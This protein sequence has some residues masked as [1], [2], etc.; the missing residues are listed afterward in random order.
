MPALYRGECAACGHHTRETSD[1]YQA[2]VVDPPVNSAHAH[3]DD[4][5]IVVLPQPASS[6]VLDELGLT[7][8]SATFAGR[9][10]AIERLFCREC[11]ELYEARRLGAAPLALGC[12]P[13][14]GVGLAG[15]V[16][17]GLT[18]GRFSI[19]VIAGILLLVIVSAV[20]DRITDRY[21][22][23]R[24][25]ERARDFDREAMCPR[26]GARA[27]RKPGT[28]SG[29]IPCP[30]CGEQALLLECVGKT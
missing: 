11:G 14:V 28:G 1:A 21:V 22:R 30:A 10:I 9:F 23:K 25:A 19:G 8:R 16:A 7:H 3:P 5:R 18:V 26:C 29:P 4:D 17:V 2:I 15:G 24:F 13:P 12:A 6:A 27:G 20:V